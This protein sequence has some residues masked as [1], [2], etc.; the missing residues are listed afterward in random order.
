MFA[1]GEGT[2]LEEKTSAAYGFSRDSIAEGVAVDCHSCL[3]SRLQRHR[4]VCAER[5]A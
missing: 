5:K 4:E 3:F 1:A 2:P